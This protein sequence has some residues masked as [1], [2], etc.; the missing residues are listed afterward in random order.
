VGFFP[1]AKIA[2]FTGQMEYI[3]FT[4]QSLGHA[5]QDIINSYDVVVPF[6]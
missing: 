4:L 2:F 1:N 6:I 5:L 3:L